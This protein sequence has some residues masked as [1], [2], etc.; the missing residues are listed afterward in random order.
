[1]PV[2]DSLSPYEGGLP[3]FESL[4]ATGPDR[5]PETLKAEVLHHAGLGDRPAPQRR[6]DLPHVGDLAEGLGLR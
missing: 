3:T 6:A 5:D 4:L 1:M 2:Y